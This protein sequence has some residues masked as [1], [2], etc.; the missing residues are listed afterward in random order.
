MNLRG[1]EKR[2][3]K[4]ISYQ[5]VIFTSVTPLPGGEAVK[6]L[7]QCLGR[8]VSR[9]DEA[10]KSF[11]S[12]SSLIVIGDMNGCWKYR[13]GVVLNFPMLPGSLFI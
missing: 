13:V 6:V 1:E 11:R 8:N 7:S 2:K 3:K 5:T 4:N 9:V 12:G 10:V